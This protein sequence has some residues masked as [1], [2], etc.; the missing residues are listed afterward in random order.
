MSDPNKL[1]LQRPY[2]MGLYPVKSNLFV[3]GILI[4]YGFGTFPLSMTK[5]NFYKTQY[6]C[7]KYLKNLKIL[8]WKKRRF[9]LRWDSSP[10]LSIAG[11]NPSAVESVFFSTGGFSNSLN[12]KFVCIICDIRVWNCLRGHL[13]TTYPIWYATSDP[14]IM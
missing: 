4:S 13:S 7:M 10:G 11:S 1:R 3:S 2:K 5:L 8:P 6:F 14:L 9:R 12:F